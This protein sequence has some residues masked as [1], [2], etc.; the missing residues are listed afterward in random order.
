M[1]IRNRAAVLVAALL[2]P[3]LMKALCSARQG[4][5]ASLVSQLAQACKSYEL[6]FAVY[7]PGKGSGSKDLATYLSKKGAKQLSYFEFSP[8]MLDNGNVIN[9]V[10]G[11]EGEAPSN[12]VHYRNNIAGQTVAFTG[13]FTDSAASPNSNT[14]GIDLS[15]SGV[16][17]K[18]GSGTLILGSTPLRA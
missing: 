9:P 1:G 15:S 16:L 7:P 6:D 14:I 4:A 2:L 11:A 18:T 8:E 5:A 17:S 12:W 13:T 3:A 10:F